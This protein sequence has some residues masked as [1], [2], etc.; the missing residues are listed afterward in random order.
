MGTLRTQIV[1]SL[2]QRPLHSNLLLWCTNGSRGAQDE[3]GRHG[4][5]NPKQPLRSLMQRP[6]GRIW[7][8]H[9]LTRTRD[10]L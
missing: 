5:N 4:Q 10:T 9:T 1:G 7:M 3:R 2:F 8:F 6:P